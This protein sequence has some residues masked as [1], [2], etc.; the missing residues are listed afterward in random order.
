M[1]RFSVKK[2]LTVFVCV[3]LIVILGIVTYTKMTP[4]LLPNIDMPYVAIVTTY[5]GATP[6]KVESNVTKPIEQSMATL[7]DIKNVQSVSSANYSMVILEFEN[8]VNMDTVSVDIL[9]DLNLLEGSWEDNVGTP[10]LLKMNPS[11]IPVSVVAVDYKGKDQ[12]SLSNFVNDTLKEKLEGTAGV[13]NIN[14]GG[15]LDEQVNVVINQT[16]IDA[17]NNKILASINSKLASTENE[18]RLQKNEIVKNQSEILTQRIELEKSKTFMPETQYNATLATLDKTDAQL[19]SALNKVNSALKKVEVEGNAARQKANIG[20]GITVDMVSKVLK[21]QNFS[22]PAGYIESG[23]KQYLV[24]VGDTINSEKEAKSIFLFASG[25][26]TVGDIKLSDVAD[27]FISDNSDKTYATING[28]NGVVMSFSKQSNYA[29]ADVTKNLN[30]KISELSKEYPGLNFTTLMNQGDYINIVVNSILSSLIWGAFFAIL[31]LLLFLRDIKPTIITIC[32][33]P[34]SLISA[35]VLMYFSGITINLISLSGLA[36]AVGMLVD[37]SVVVIENIFR[38]RRLGVPAPKAAVAG[39]KQV[40][41]AVTASTLTTI[42]VFIPIIFT[43]GITRELFTDMALTI[44][45]ALIASLVISLTLVPAMSSKML[46]DTNINDTKWFLKALDKYGLSVKWA[47]SH[48]AIIIIAVLVLL[49]GSLGLTLQKGY[50]FMPAI[51]SP[52]LNVTLEMPKGTELAVTRVMADKVIKKIKTIDEV[53]NVGAMLSSGNMMG[54]SIGNNFDTA[55][56]NMYVMLK[57]NIT[58]TSMEIANEINEACKNFDCKVTASSSSISDFTTALGDS[59]VII[60][61]YGTDLPDLQKAATEVAAGLENVKGIGEISNGIEDTDPELHFK[62]DKTEAMKNGLTV[63]QVYA[64]IADKM[65]AETTATTVN[66]GGDAYDVV[67]SNDGNPELTIDYIENLKI[68]AKDSNGNDAKI[69]IKDVATVEYGQTLHSINRDNQVRYLTVTGTVAQ[70]YNVTKVTSATENVISKIEL[71]NGI[72]Y[73]FS[74]ENETIMD[75]MSDLLLMLILGILFVYLIMVAQF[76]SLKSPFIIMFTIPLAFTGG[77]LGLLITGKEV[78]VIAMVGFV[79]LCGII[80]NN[81]IVLVDYINQL[82]GQGKT[83]QEAIIEGGKTRMRPI[84]MT[85]LTTIL[86][87]T[88]MALGRNSGTD[89]MQPIAI[90]CIG[91][92]LYATLLTLYVVPI[93]YDILNKEEYKQ[94]TDEDVDISQLEIYKEGKL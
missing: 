66:I 76:Q 44:A 49:L 15:L 42:A 92:L 85:S 34:I 77:L 55:T 57:N 59:G 3:V 1:P 67:V 16:K 61:V 84:L 22:M 12:I 13:A 65:N 40:A 7:E 81:G 10:F 17:I 79:M 29:T 27:V 11:M 94:L 30:D 58:K 62:V 71:P 80:V 31:I 69:K 70:G 83:K 28:N 78:S 39:A 73:K 87:L 26:D 5:P 45:Y 24:S 50:S 91:G 82:R 4:D 36:V 93:I 25:V 19:K 60:K 37:N 38:L 43:S 72:T 54:I 14:T 52:Q 75:S 21:A 2:P 18:I 64:A 68:S 32:S 56:V 41:G 9:Q 35:I 33:I 90:V 46:L 48:K 6:E 23:K 88:V 89:M 63:A 86:G 53:D 74:G 51:N 8:S 47:L 20:S